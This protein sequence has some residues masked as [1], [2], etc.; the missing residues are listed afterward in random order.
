MFEQAEQTLVTC[1]PFTASAFRFDS[2]VCGV[3]LRSDVGEI[4]VLPFQGQQ[5]WSAA[6]D[7]GHG[8]RELTM[9]SMFHEPRPTRD[10][11]ATFGGFL[12]HCGISGAGGPSPEDSHPLHGEL[13]NALYQQ[14]YL[15]TGED[16]GGPYIGIGGRYQ[17]TVAFA[18]N[19][20]AEPLVKLHAGRTL[21]HVAMTVRNLKQSPMDLMYLAH[22]NFRPVNGSRLIY[23]APSTPEHVRVR[24]AIPAHIQPGPGYVEFI[25]QLQENP[26]LHET[27]TPDLVFDPEGVFFIDYQADA[28]GWAHSM[29]LHPDGS[30]DYVRH[31]LAQL[32][33]ATRWIS[34]TPDQDAIALA[35]VGTCEPEG[36]LAE[37]AKGNIVTLGAGEDF[38]CAFDVGALPAAE[39]ERIK[40]IVADV[41]A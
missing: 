3:R 23:S 20:A 2:G 8:R 21:I 17:H 37:K 35:E 30:A 14:A 34:R 33:K 25:Q 1:E 28:D 32:P 18:L 4:V 39:A 24:A 36:Y 5:I 9:R 19:Y 27:L 38:A 6:F 26:G 11:L 29:Q 12:Q 40:R 15:V 16:D 10:F 22:V 7:V 31:R 41:L 13:P